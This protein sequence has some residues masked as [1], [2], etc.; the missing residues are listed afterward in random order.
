MSIV[1]SKRMGRSR[2]GAVSVPTEIILHI[3]I[4]AFA[5]MCIIPFIFCVIIS[6]TSKASIINKGFSFVPQSW[7][8]DGY[9]Y[10][11]SNAHQL[12]ISYFN[13]IFVSLVGTAISVFIC[14]LYA[15]ALYRKDFKYRKFFTFFAIITMMFSGGLA[16]TYQVSKNLLG[17]SDNYWALIVPM[18]VNPFNLIIMRTFFK[19]SIPDAIIE[20]AAIDGSGEYNTLFKIVLPISLPGIATISLLTILSYWNDWFQALLY[21]N[22]SKYYPLQYLLWQMQS[23]VDFLAANAGKGL[24]TAVNVATMPTQ[25]FR[26]ALVVI[27]VIPIALAY[28]FFQRYVISGLT[29]GSVK[30]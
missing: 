21:I 19:S 10:V 1:K 25:S 27:I 28:P 30:E 13:S 23:Q 2:L 29:V 7:T 9:N 12:W 20:A 18:L 16:P 26:M 15:Y 24:T 5:L 11:F 6:F 17:L 4:A 14:I 3:V 22:D 8:L